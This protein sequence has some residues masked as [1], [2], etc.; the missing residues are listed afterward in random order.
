VP[1]LYAV[2]KVANVYLES[3]ISEGIP[4]PAKLDPNGPKP[5]IAMPAWG[6][7]ISEGEMADLII[8]LRSLKP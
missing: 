8:Y 3:F 5:P 7:K 2:K 4:E 1:S 6:E